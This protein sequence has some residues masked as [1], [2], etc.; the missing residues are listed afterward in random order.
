MLFCRAGPGYCAGDERWRDAARSRVKD[1]RR[2]H[3]GEFLHG[4]E[5]LRRSCA[6]ALCRRRHR[7]GRRRDDVLRQMRT[8]NPS[9]N[10]CATLSGGKS[11]RDA[12]LLREGPAARREGERRLDD[13]H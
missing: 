11:E 2:S 12:E 13:W 10:C 8:S 9:A 7:G 5:V 1:E 3:D 6:A 4:A